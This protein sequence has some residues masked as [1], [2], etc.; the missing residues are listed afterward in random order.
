MAGFASRPLIYFR[1]KSGIFIFLAKIPG[2][3]PNVSRNLSDYIKSGVQTATIL[4]KNFCQKSNFLVIFCIS[5]ASAFEARHIIRNTWGRSNN[6]NKWNVS[7]YFLIGQT[8]NLR[9]QQKI[10]EEAQQF[11]DIIQENF[12]DTYNNLTIKSAMML[13][14]FTQ[15]CHSTSYLLKID[16]DMHLNLPILMDTLKIRNETHN[17]LMGSAICNST[18]LRNSQCKWYAGP[19]DY[20]TE[21]EYP[22][23]VA[24]GS[25]C[26]SADAAGK[27]LNVALTIPIFYIEDIYFTGLC[28]QKL[29]LK[30]THDFRFTF[31]F[32]RDDP[33]LYREL[34]TIHIHDWKVRKYISSSIQNEHHECDINNN[35]FLA[36]KWLLSNIFFVNNPVKE[37]IGC[38]NVRLNTQDSVLYNRIRL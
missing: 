27:L 35:I 29:G 25:Y 2:W 7:L 32:L 37:D 38:N 8:T 12:L 24:G 20:F 36:Y 1:S 9:K 5:R 33:C 22:D 16:D 28:A 10:I 11:D 4:P 14:S 6:V 26:M 3:G 21:M 18:P 13:K 19:L 31:P 17:L 34:I 15:H 30:L 23:Y